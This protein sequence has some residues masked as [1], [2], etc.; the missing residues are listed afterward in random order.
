MIQKIALVLKDE[1]EL[2]L[3]IHAWKSLVESAGVS[4]RQKPN[5]NDQFDDTFRES[6][7]FDCGHGVPLWAYSDDELKKIIDAKMGQSQNEMK[8]KK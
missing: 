6:C 1:D 3:H 8:T 5:W 7:S 2:G 4:F